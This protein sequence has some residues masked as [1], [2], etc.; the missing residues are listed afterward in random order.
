MGFSRQ[1]FIDLGFSNFAL[2]VRVL[3]IYFPW[4]VHTSQR[5]HSKEY[6][7]NYFNRLRMYFLDSV[8]LRWIL[9]G[10]DDS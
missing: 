5:K 1:N 9:S 6:N 2:G 4:T 8:E 10:K 3:P 7:P